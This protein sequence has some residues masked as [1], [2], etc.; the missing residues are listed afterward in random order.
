[1]RYNCGIYKIENIITGD[2]YIG[3]SINL[4]NR[5]HKHFYT[6]KKN[7]HFNI[8]LQNSYNKYGKES[9]I[10]QVILYCEPFDTNYYEQKIVDNF[11]PKYNK[12]KNCIVSNVG[13][14]HNEE[15]RKKISI[16]SM[17]RMKGYKHNNETLRKMSDAQK[18]AHKKRKFLNCKNTSISLTIRESD[19]NIYFSKEEIDNIKILKNS[20]KERFLFGLFLFY[21]MKILSEKIKKIEVKNYLEIKENVLKRSK[22]LGKI[23]DFNYKK[24][25]ETLKY[26]EKLKIINIENN[27][28]FFKEYSHNKYFIINSKNNFSNGIIEYFNFFGFPCEK[29]GKRIKRKCNR[30]KYCPDC[31]IE[32]NRERSRVSII[33]KRN[34]K[35]SSI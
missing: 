3:Q 34:Y 10:F 32:I 17:G 2:F 16:S 1:M 25:I 28:I 20:E 14:I 31:L 5:K 29:C 19:K 15:F 27:Q 22:N 4:K 9:F 24:L 35:K 21:K 33:K 7:N 6:L 13:I 8:H 12:R 11:N 18:Q 30:Q 23:K 26:F